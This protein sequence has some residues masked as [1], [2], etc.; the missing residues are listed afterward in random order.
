M[1]ESLP[2]WQSS[3]PWVVVKRLF[4]LFIQCQCCWHFFHFLQDRNSPSQASQQYSPDILHEPV[5]PYT[6]WLS[7]RCLHLSPTLCFNH[8]HHNLVRRVQGHLVTH[9]SLLTWWNFAK[10]RKSL[11]WNDFSRYQ[12][13]AVLNCASITQTHEV[14]KGLGALFCLPDPSV[15]GRKFLAAGIHTSECGLPHIPKQVSKG[16]WECRCDSQ[17][18]LRTNCTSMP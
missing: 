9:Q 12:S 2:S 18:L 8:I 10:V 13:L 4:P 1:P 5:K 7:L 14:P 17:I 16:K 3:C 15:P 6:I 11:F